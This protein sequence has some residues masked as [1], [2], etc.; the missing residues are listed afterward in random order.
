LVLPLLEAEVGFAHGGATT[1]TKEKI[2]P[3]YRKSDPEELVKRFNERKLP[4][5]VGTSCIATGTDIQAVKTMI[6]LRGGRSEIELSQGIGRG[7]RMFQLGDY[8]KD[9][10]NFFDFDVCNVPTLH[11]HTL[12]RIRICKEI[13]PNVHFIDLEPIDAN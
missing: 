8:T 11:R 5:L 1:A 10:F 7:T 2:P 3:D 12:E 13:Y 6:Y 9:S 4:I